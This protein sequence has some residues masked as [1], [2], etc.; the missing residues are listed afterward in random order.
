VKSR[1]VG[2]E[3]LRRGKSRPRDDPAEAAKDR[4]DFESLSP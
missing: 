4:A 1:L 2:L 3:A